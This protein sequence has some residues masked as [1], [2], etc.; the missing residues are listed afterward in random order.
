MQTN[1]EKKLVVSQLLPESV[2][3][4]LSGLVA[5]ISSA[6]CSMT[7]ASKSRRVPLVGVDIADDCAVASVPWKMEFHTSVR[8]F[9]LFFS[10]CSARNFS[11]RAR[12]SSQR[13]FS[14]LR[15][16]ALAVPHSFAQSSNVVW[17]ASWIYRTET[18]V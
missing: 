18:L 15:A 7:L 8:I 4:G 2:S 5:P 14:C 3:H 17:S 16:A 1:E 13:C 10:R 6:S 11:R 9:S 12:T